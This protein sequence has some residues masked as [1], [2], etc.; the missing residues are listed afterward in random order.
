MTFDCSTQLETTFD[1]GQLALVLAREIHKRVRRSRMKHGDCVGGSRAPEYISWRNMLKRCHNENDTAYHNY[2]G[3]GIRVCPSW[4]KS[5]AR[6]LA[7][8]GRKPTPRHTLDRIDVDKGYWP[9]NCRWA[10]YA[11]QNANKR[12]SRVTPDEWRQHGGKVLP[13][14]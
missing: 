11:E 8:M 9:S 12:N 1:A 2:G 13:W 10:T 7:D 14:M 6:F 4:R 3:R 5:Y